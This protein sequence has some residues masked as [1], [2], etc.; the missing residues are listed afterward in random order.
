M[1]NLNNTSNC[2]YEQYMKD[3][4]GLLSRN[5]VVKTYKRANPE[6]WDGFERGIDVLVQIQWKKEPIFEFIIEKLFWT[7]RN[8]NKEDRVYMR[9][10]ADQKIEMIK[11]GI[12]KKIKPKKVTPKKKVI[13]NKVGYTQDLFESAKK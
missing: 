7:Q 12:I 2:S 1:N 13:S 8:L 4:L 3:Q 6:R 11:S 9:R 5:F 10:W